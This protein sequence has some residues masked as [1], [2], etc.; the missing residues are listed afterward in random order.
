[1]GISAVVIIT[2]RGLGSPGGI[3][4]V[5]EGVK[6]TLSLL[7]RRGVVDGF[8]ENGPGSF[9]VQVAPLTRLFEAPRRKRDIHKGTGVVART[10]TTLAGLAPEIVADLRKLAQ[11][12]LHALGVAD[13]ESLV[14][15][16]MIRQF[17]MLTNSLPD[18]AD[19]E[20]LLREA[21]QRALREYEDG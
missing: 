5:R 18:G 12:A 20:A 21:I 6:K 3:G 11:S 8:S 14:E 4:V 15:S 1:M 16:E 19:R 7:R 13:A 2:G 9:S 10:G 17:T